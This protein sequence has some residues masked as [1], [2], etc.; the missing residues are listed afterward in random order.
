MILQSTFFLI[1]H[2]YRF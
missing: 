2:K 1:E